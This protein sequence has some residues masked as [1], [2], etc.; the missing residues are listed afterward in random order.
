MGDEF[1][2]FN[3]QEIDTAL[4]DKVVENF[5]RLGDLPSPS[6][7]VQLI[8][9]FEDG[10]EFDIFGST[11]VQHFL[12]QVARGDAVVKLVQQRYPNLR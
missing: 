8:F 12:T 4:M 6:E 7:K 2:R 11:N 3:D 5:S 10:T 9:R 1:L